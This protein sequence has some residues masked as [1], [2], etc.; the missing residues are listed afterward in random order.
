MTSP[1]PVRL[2]K[3]LEAGATVEAEWDGRTFSALGRADKDRYINRLSAAIDAYTAALSESKEQTTADGWI[4][5]KGGECPVDGETL[6]SV[7][8]RGSWL[9]SEGTHA[10][11]ATAFDWHHM[12]PAQ[13]DDIVSWRLAK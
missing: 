12:V 8:F 11:A 2:R 1:S 6:V 7:K 5:W 9:G 13:K 3:A 4:E 10:V